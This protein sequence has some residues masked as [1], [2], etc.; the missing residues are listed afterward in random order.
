MSVHVS[1]WVWK[2][3]KSEGL[4]R[5][6]LLAIADMVNDQGICWPSNVYLAK[7]CRVSKRTIQ[8]HVSKLVRLGEL[9]IEKK[10]G[11]VEGKRTTNRFRVIHPKLK[12]SPKIPLARKSL[13]P[14]QTMPYEEYLQTPEWK[15]LCEKN[16]NKLVFVASSAT[17]PRN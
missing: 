1:S 13:S 9:K 7:K 8:E 15:A 4:T 17:A 14:L 16:G 6:I 3:S 10:G 11:V 2:H 12:R 5:I